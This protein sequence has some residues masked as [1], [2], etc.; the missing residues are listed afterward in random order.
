MKAVTVADTG[1]VEEAALFLSGGGEDGA[2]VGGTFD[3]V[4]TFTVIFFGI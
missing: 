4:Y 3:C 2:S 1:V